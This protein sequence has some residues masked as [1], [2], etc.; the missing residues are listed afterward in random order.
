M[1]AKHLQVPAAPVTLWV[2]EWGITA[3]PFSGSC[4]CLE[5]QVPRDVSEEPQGKDNAGQRKMRGVSG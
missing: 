2:K 4:L 3:G 5:P 1:V